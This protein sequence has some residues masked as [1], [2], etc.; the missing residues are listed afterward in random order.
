M[1]NKVVFLIERFITWVYSRDIYYI[2]YK[3]NILG[4]HYERGKTK[5]Y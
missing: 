3:S 1:I 2:P 4:E 5:T